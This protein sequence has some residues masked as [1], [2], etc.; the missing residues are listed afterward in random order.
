M[1]RSLIL[2]PTGNR[3]R[4]VNDR[5][6]YATSLYPTDTVLATGVPAHSYNVA[7]ADTKLS[8]GAVWVYFLFPYSELKL[9]APS[10][11]TNSRN[12]NDFFGQSV[13]MAGDYLFIGSPGH[14]YDLAGANSVDLAGCVW[15]FQ[16]Q[17]NGFVFHQ[18]LI[19]PA[20]RTSNDFFGYSVAAAIIGGVEVVAIGSPN[21]DLDAGGLNPVTQSGA[22]HVFKKDGGNVFQFESKIVPTGVNARNSSDSFGYALS[23]SSNFLA[24]SSENNFDAAG[25][26]EIAP[27]ERFTG[28]VFIY[29]T[30]TWTQS[31][32]VVPTSLNA[33]ATATDGTRNVGGGFGEAVSI[34]NDRLVVGSPYHG[35]DGS[36]AASQVNKGAVFLFDT[37]AWNETEKLVSPQIAQ[38]DNSLYGDATQAE[39]GGAVSQ[40]SDSVFVFDGNPLD[41]AELN[42][43]SGAHSVYAFYDN[44]TNWVSYQKLVGQGKNARIA[45][46]TMATANVLEG[47][48]FGFSIAAGEDHLVISDPLQSFDR[49]GDS[50]IDSAGRVYVFEK[51]IETSSETFGLPNGS[52][53]SNAG[54]SWTKTTNDQSEIV[55]DNGVTFF[56]NEYTITDPP[57]TK[58]AELIFSLSNED[59][60]EAYPDF[61]G[62]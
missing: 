34:R 60:Y 11:E 19:Q 48:R 27:D 4:N 54:L 28:A 55:Q 17:G 47:R 26:N 43:I 30:T 16:R 39:F 37:A 18:K 50:R 35:Y 3:A 5:F 45:P 29:E 58:T 56:R 14:D 53:S 36:G 6:G 46:N 9:V 49:V 41:H 21:H 7:G 40:N 57:Q 59:H 61:S 25:A 42:P 12:I 51:V 1:K 31:A 8:A 52:F 44:G 32:K 24:V 15:V 20:N 62:S 38:A 2:T 13:A 22:V 23:L 10:S 33:R